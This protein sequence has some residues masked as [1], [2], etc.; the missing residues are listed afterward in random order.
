MWPPASA[1]SCSGSTCRD[2]DEPPA[3]MTNPLTRRSLRAD[4]RDTA[5]KGFAHVD[6]L[7]E[8]ALLR[9]LVRELGAGP[10]RGMAG[11][12]GKAG[13]RMEIDGFDLEAPFEGFPVL[14]EL[15]SAF[16][17]RV[18]RDGDGIRGLRT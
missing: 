12:F 18:V 7:V 1:S 6:G 11:T 16:E 3:R 14:S 2:S 10:L 4:L 13:V 5:S 9:V 8:P 15:V 17:K